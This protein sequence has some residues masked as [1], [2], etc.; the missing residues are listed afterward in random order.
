MGGWAALVDTTLDLLLPAVCPLC[1]AAP[2][3]DL[4]PGCRAALPALLDPCPAC[5]M[6][7][8]RPDCRHCG[9]A[10]VPHLASVRVGFAYRAAMRRLITDAKAGERPAATRAAAALVPDPAAA[11]DAVAPVP[12]SPGRRSGP[13]LA[14]AAARVLARR[15]G[16]PCLSL[17]A[18]TRHAR[19]QH[20]LSR[21]ERW[22]NVVGLFIARRA[23]PPRL[24]L[25]DDILTSGATASRAAAALRQRGAAEVHG[26]FLARTLL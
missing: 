12:P 9:G 16:V 14:S 5:G 10:G 11:V 7:H 23:A 15:L 21:A 3:A 4:C 6:P 24:A 2:G 19:E 1:R 26:C 13:H 25:V 20:R 18:C 17:L 22:R 8:A